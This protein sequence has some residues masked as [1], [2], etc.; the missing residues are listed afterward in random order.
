MSLTYNDEKLLAST[1]FNVNQR[2]YRYFGQFQNPLI[3][4]Q[5]EI[6]SCE[7]LI[8]KRFKTLPLLI[9]I[10]RTCNFDNLLDLIIQKTLALLHFVV[11]LL[12]LSEIHFC[13]KSSFSC[14]SLEVP[15]L[16]HNLALFEKI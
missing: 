12:N 16:P 5:I 3:K 11:N 13:D 15:F 1:Q 4:H 14:L 9:Q 6:S 10:L 8:S 7:I 2:S